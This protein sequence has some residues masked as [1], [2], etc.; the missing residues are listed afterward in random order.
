MLS[1]RKQG[2]LI[3]D[4]IRSFQKYY[5]SPLG[6]LELCANESS[7]TSVQF[8]EELPDQF[9]NENEVLNECCKQLNKYFIGQLKFFNISIESNGTMFQNEVWNHLM[10]I[11]FGKTTSYMKLAQSM[12]NKKFA[13]AIG[14]SVSKNKTLILI[15]CHRVIGS[16]G[17]LVGYAGGL[18]R[19]KWLLDFERS[20]EPIRQTKL[21]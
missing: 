17:D 13:R 18:W 10:K 8:V 11:P 6:T 4:V 12:S 5:S 15:P 3:L 7:I 16:K 19:K 21:F 14:S 9:E 1:V 2:L 20:F